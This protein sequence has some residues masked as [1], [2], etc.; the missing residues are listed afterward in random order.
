MRRN[1]ID[2]EHQLSHYLLKIAKNYSGPDGKPLRHP[3]QRMAQLFY[4]DN[5]VAKKVLDKLVTSKQHVKQDST[6]T[7]DLSLLTDAIGQLAEITKGQRVDADYTI[8]E[9]D[10]K[11]IENSTHEQD[12]GV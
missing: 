11:L 1:K 3:M 8:E 4:T 7:A 12:G 9:K 6:H 2:H 5:E 10:N